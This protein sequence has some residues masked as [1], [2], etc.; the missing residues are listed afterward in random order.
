A[1]GTP[2]NTAVKCQFDGEPRVERKP[3]ELTPGTTKVVEFE[4]GGFAPGGHTAE[5][6]VDTPD[7]LAGDNYRYVTFESREP[8]KRL[9]SCGD[10]HDA[11]LW[12]AAVNSQKYF[13][14]DVREKADGLTPADLANYRAVCLLSVTA[15]SDTLW[16]MLEE[17][18]KKGGG[19]VVTPP[20]GGLN[21]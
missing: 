2:F 13:Q 8:Q 10:Q 16:L 14:C 4:R 21:R 11:I 7:S 3:V 6:S 5:G 19:L 17:Y 1:T 18:V 9:V 12:S 15:P 20:I